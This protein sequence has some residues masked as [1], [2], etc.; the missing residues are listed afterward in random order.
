MVTALGVYDCRNFIVTHLAASVL[1]EDGS[2][3]AK[4]RVAL[5]PTANGCNDVPTAGYSAI[6]AQV[7]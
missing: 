2:T 4:I 3:R 7:K 5:K 6:G 1:I